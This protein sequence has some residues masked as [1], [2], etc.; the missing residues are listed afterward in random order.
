MT[1]APNGENHA[2]P[3]DRVA[4]PAPGRAREARE[5]RDSPRPDDPARL[6]MKMR[7]RL[8]EVFPDVLPRTTADERDPGEGHGMD[9]EFYRSNR[10]P[11]H[12]R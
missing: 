9:A 1:V 5:V 7:R 10:P 2:A 8:D 3:D 12:D 11:H 6:D 4:S